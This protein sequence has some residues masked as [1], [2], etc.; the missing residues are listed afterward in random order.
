MRT[1]RQLKPQHNVHQKAGRVTSDEW[2]V[3]SDERQ[4][5]R[6]Q[7]TGHRRQEYWLYTISKFLYFSKSY[8]N[9]IYSPLIHPPLS[10]LTYHLSPITYH[11]SPISPLTYPLTYHLSPITSHLSPLYSI[12]NPT[13]LLQCCT[14][15][16]STSHLTPLT[17]HLSPL[18]SI[19]NPTQHHNPLCPVLFFNS[20][21]HHLPHTHTHTHTTPSS[22][23]ISSPFFFR[24]LPS[25]STF[26]SKQKPV[27]NTASGTVPGGTR[28][29]H[30]IVLAMRTVFR[31]HGTLVLY[32]QCLFLLLLCTNYHCNGQG[33]T[34]ME[35]HINN[36]SFPSS[37]LLQ[38]FWSFHSPISFSFYSSTQLTL[39]EGSKHSL[40]FVLHTLLHI[41]QHHFQT[42]SF[43]ERVTRV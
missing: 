13:L 37:L 40:F 20:Y 11:P 22:I 2:R 1:C 33:E 36:G 34:G 41:H 30:I 3:T 8:A 32:L 29:L 42:W 18:C 5:T 43:Q 38:S 21:P 26:C 28:R 14:T 16:S 19:S 27:V 39:T 15:H 31:I 9:K 25:V 10:P 24:S 35:D 7:E 23:S 4:S 12:Y 17:S 6:K